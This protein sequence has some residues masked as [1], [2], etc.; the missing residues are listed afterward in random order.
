MSYAALNEVYA[1]VMQGQKD[2]AAM[3]VMQNS[4]G[5]S[6][7]E[8]NIPAKQEGVRKNLCQWTMRNIKPKLPPTLQTY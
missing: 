4:V 8:L 3:K 5:L 1:I 2:I 6:C 7:N